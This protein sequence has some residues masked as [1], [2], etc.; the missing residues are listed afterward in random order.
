MCVNGAHIS[1]SDASQQPSYCLEM[2][3]THDDN[4][5]L[6]ARAPSR[7]YDEFHSIFDGDG[8][9]RDFTAFSRTEQRT[10]VHVN[11]CAPRAHASIIYYA[12]HSLNSV[13]NMRCLMHAPRYRCIA[14]IIVCVCARLGLYVLHIKLK[15][16][17]DFG[18]HIPTPL[19]ERGREKN[20][21][22]FVI[23]GVAS[24]STG[25]PQNSWSCASNAS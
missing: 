15:Q 21:C 17:V 20:R 1:S 12:C 16:Y 18:R 7:I 23:G 14:S 22:A 25:I 2:P 19:R 4:V 5:L 3:K 13:W 8:F 9:Q 11:V 6:L 10:S 24:A